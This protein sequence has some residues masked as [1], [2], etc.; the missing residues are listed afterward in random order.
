MEGVAEAAFYNTGQVCCGGSK[1]LVQKGVA[2]RFV[3]KLKQFVREK[4]SRKMGDPRD[5]Q[6]VVGPLVSRVQLDKV[7][8]FLRVA[9]EEG[10]RVV[11][12]GECGAAVGRRMGG[13]FA[14][15]YWVEPTIVL[16]LDA[17]ESECAMHEM[18]GPIL[19]VHTFETEAQALRIA[20]SVRY[21]L[22]ASVW[23]RDGRRG[24]R[25]ARELEAGSVWINCYEYSDARM[26][27]GGFKDSGLHR[28]NGMHSID[29]FSEI[30]SIVSKL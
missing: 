19:T 20:N 28:E 3:S 2:E 7:C 23:T 30:K 10:G 26:P 27:F 24:H 1:L 8:R 15:G 16:G 6:S 25:M 29:F 14:E 11:L 9:R 18:F 17:A 21:G 4:Y 22:A 13:A 12:G 5:A